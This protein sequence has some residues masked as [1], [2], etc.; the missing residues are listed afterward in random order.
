MW[1]EAVP[2]SANSAR[3][4]TATS[5][6]RRAFVSKWTAR[7][8]HV[9]PR[10]ERPLRCCGRAFEQAEHRPGPDG[11]AHIRRTSTITW[12]VEHASDPSHAPAIGERTAS[13]QSVRACQGPRLVAVRSMQ[14][15]MQRRRSCCC[16]QRAC[17]ASHPQ[18][19]FRCHVLFPAGISR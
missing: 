12:H 2:K 19:L 11:E 4:S 1:C 17:G 13:F 18:A 15:G 3:Y 8:C 9:W 7:H 14:H 16:S 10:G 6:R 5:A